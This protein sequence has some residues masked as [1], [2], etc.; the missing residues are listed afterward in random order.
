MVLLYVLLSIKE[1][2]A[3][4]LFSSTNRTTAARRPIDRS[5]LHMP[6]KAS[7]SPPPPSS[8]IARQGLASDHQ[9]YHLEVLH[10]VS[11]YKSSCLAALRRRM[12]SREETLHCRDHGQGRSSSSLCDTTPSNCHGFSTRKRLFLSFRLGEK[13]RNRKDHTEDSRQ[14][15]LGV[16]LMK[17]SIIQ[18]P[19][20]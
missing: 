6:R 20:R 7:S 2:L 16:N 4:S 10:S 14:V 5:I 12:E 8:W 18:L 11:I 17:N 3:C 15:T 19:P 13:P 1:D 9:D